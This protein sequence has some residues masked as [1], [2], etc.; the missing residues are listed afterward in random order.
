MSKP[1]FTSARWIKSSRSEPSNACVQLAV[2]DDV[3]GV[4]DSKLDTTN[5]VLTFTRAEFTAWLEG[6]KA[7]ESI[8]W[9]E[10]TVPRPWASACVCRRNSCGESCRPRVADLECER[11]PRRS[12]IH[13]SLPC[14]R[15]RGCN[16]TRHYHD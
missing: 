10:R 8:T 13:S 1:D 9:S 11:P 15:S 5:P 2:V 12:M 14:A 16:A 4:R 7:G 6:A 3:I